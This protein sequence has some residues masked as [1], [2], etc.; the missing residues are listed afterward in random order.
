VEHEE[1]MNLLGLE[2]VESFELAPNEAWI[3]FNKDAPQ[4]PHELRGNLIVPCVV[5]G[6]VGQAQRTLK[7]LQA[8]SLRPN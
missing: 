6:D 8:I 4:V 3:V 2:I 5:A 1:L 7:L